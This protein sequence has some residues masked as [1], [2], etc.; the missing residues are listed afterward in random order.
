M[1]SRIGILQTAVFVCL[2]VCICLNYS[3]FWKSL[4]PL[5]GSCQLHNPFNNSLIRVSSKTTRSIEATRKKWA[6][7]LNGRVHKQL[8][9]Q[10]TYRQ[11]SV[12]SEQLNVTL[13]TWSC[14]FFFFFFFFFF[15]L[16]LSLSHTSCIYSYIHIYIYTRV[17]TVYIYISP[18][19]V[20]YQTITC[21][22]KSSNL[23]SSV[24]TWW[25][26]MLLTETCSCFSRLTFRNPASYI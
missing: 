11:L 2:L 15:S 25:M 16:S 26:L 4:I 9:V 20:W 22:C 7:V 17:Y 5:H 24:T 10:S 19:Y 12:L 21:S 13:L 3:S 23:L 1:P 6:F 18:S 14:V 8:T